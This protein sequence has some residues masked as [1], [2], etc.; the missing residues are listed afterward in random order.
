MIGDGATGAERWIGAE[1]ARFVAGSWLFH[2]PHLVCRPSV[3]GLVLPL[4]LRELSSE[5]SQDAGDLSFGFV[6]DVTAVN[7]LAQTLHTQPTH[8]QIYTQA[9]LS[10]WSKQHAEMHLYRK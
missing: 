8:N 5:R 2:R 9:Q 10:G 3:K 7:C 1:A 4:Q 6:R